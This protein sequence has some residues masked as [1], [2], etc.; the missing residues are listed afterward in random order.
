MPTKKVAKKKAVK[1]AIE[2]VVETEPVERTPVVSAPDTTVTVTAEVEPPAEP[3]SETN[4]VSEPVEPKQPEQFAYY[5]GNRAVVMVKELN[6]R[7]YYEVKTNIETVVLTK[8]ELDREV[9]YR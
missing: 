7:S 4:E 9:T 3:V 6:G 1:K 5:R 2:P 8:D